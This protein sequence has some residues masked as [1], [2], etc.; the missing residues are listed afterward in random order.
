[1]KFL[2]A[3]LAIVFS[4]N[5]MAASS[6]WQEGVQYKTVDPAG[7]TSEPTV[8]EVFS[9]GCPVCFGRE[10]EIANWL[11]SKPA[12][13]KFIRIPHYGVHDDNGL[14]IKIFYTA[15]ALGISEQIHK[16]LFDLIHVKH[17]HILNENDAVK[18]LVSFG[19]SDAVVRETMSGFFVD[20]KIRAAK[21]FVQKYHMDS[22]PAFIINNKYNTDGQMAGENLFK[23]LSELPLSK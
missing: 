10:P 12:N 17:E 5:V 2:N 9:Y 3:L 1:M 7:K 14:L 11:K 13:I 6:N 22:V 20:T 16:P 19:K 8:V 21:A 4:F 23:I 15:E 18:F